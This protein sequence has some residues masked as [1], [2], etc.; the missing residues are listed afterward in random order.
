MYGLWVNV[1]DAVIAMKAIRGDQI[2]IEEKVRLGKLGIRVI[3][4]LA[5]RE[6]D[7]ILKY[8]GYE[9]ELQEPKMSTVWVEVKPCS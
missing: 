3:E 6:K 7:I 1:D 8:T 5:R 9:T 4:S 2:S